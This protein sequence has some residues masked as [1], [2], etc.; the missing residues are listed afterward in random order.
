MLFAWSDPVSNCL[1][2]NLA[3]IINCEHFVWSVHYR[4]TIFFLNF[5]VFT[6]LNNAE[7][8]KE[9]TPGKLKYFTRNCG[10]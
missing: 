3:P 8:P 5:L 1:I 2:R 7:K 10:F 6:F 4:D 9:K